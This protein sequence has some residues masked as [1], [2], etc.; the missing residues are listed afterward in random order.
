MNSPMSFYFRG[1]KEEP[2]SS[3]APWPWQ[4]YPWAHI[5]IP[6][7]GEWTVSLEKG[8]LHVRSD[9]M[10]LLKP[11]VSHSVR[12]TS[13][14]PMTTIYALLSW[15][16][17]GEDVIA[18]C[19]FPTVLPKDTAEKVLPLI[20]GLIG[21]AK[22]K[23]LAFAAR[24]QQLG[25]SLLEIISPHAVHPLDDALS[26]DDSRISHAL[27]HIDMHWNENIGRRDLAALAGLSP[28]R[29]HTVFRNAT[30]F[31]PTAYITATRL[32]HASEMLESTKTSIGDIAAACGFSSVY[33]FSRCFSAHKKTTP[34][35]YRNFHRA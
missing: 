2:R 22:Q 21:N 33:Y 7:G 18:Q 32:A 6:M 29:F 14:G 10:L 30:G 16:W 15:R 4:K 1:G 25:F 13:D 28:S 31:S 24:E 23:G 3:L 5:E 27:D 9:E 26:R 8:T 34:S 19:R 17:R 11:G 12:K 20:R 35:A